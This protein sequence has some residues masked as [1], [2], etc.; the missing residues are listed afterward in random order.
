MEKNGGC[1]S[2]TCTV[3]K[4]TFCWKCVKIWSEHLKLTNGQHDCV[5]PTDKNLTVTYEFKKDNK[6]IKIKEGN[7]HENSFFHR[8][9]RSKQ[10]NRVRTKN[11]KRILESIKI[12][13]LCE[14]FDNL[15]FNDQFKAELTKRQETRSFLQT[16]LS[17]LN[18]LHF[19]CEH[20]YLLLTDNSIEKSS[21]NT[22][23]SILKIIEL[24]VWRIHNIFEVNNGIQVINDLEELVRKGINCLKKINNINI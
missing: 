17:F 16:T 9:Q 22:I 6:K 2:M 10:N 15:T 1:N 4:E 23:I 21:R 19:I 7:Y 12:G 3:C 13:E 11:I 5:V 14:N 20:T 8:E 24:I 18:E